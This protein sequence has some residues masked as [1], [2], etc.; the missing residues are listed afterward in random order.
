M[1]LSAKWS[2]AQLQAAAQVIPNTEG[3]E[4]GYVFGMPDLTTMS[5]TATND[6]MSATYPGLVVSPACDWKR[7]TPK[8]FTARLWKT[9]G[10]GRSSRAIS[11]VDSAPAGLPDSAFGALFRLL[12]EI[13]QR[14]NVAGR[15]T[16]TAPGLAHSPRASTFPPG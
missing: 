13:V 9:G 6:W 7:Q 5:T 12:A 15:G 16:S 2:E 3:I 8:S 10:A 4:R 1:M 11:R 14:T